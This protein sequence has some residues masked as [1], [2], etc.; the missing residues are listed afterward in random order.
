MSHL[1]LMIVL[2]LWTLLVTDGPLAVAQ[3]QL[4]SGEYFVTQ[5]WSQ[6]KDYR[7]VFYVS[8]PKRRGQQKLPV[9]IFLHGNGGNAK[10]AM[11]GFLA[12]H[13]IM[14]TR[15]VMVF[16]GGYAKSWNIVSERSKAD[17]RGFIEEIVRKLAAFDNVQPDTFTIMGASN[18]AALVNQLAIE[19]RLSNIRNYVSS[20]SPLN[21][22]QHDGQNFKAKGDDNNYQAVVTPMTGKRLMNISGM[23]DKLVPYRGGP[24]KVIPAKGGKLAF[25][26]AEESI[27]RWARQMEYDG[28]KLSAPTTIDGKL[29]IF[30]Y[31]DGDVVHYKVVDE[32]HN[33]TG[34][35]SESILLDFLEQD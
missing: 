32:G 27:F 33:A 15:Y 11:K 17:D 29:E 16:P 24:S 19:C 31:L 26:D 9:F 12:R 35:I 14:A 34:Q 5:S 28:D 25:V 2:A 1:Q 3:E 8:V 21:V 10:G 7:R 20:V 4:T 6:E 30:S 18:G 22:Y 13:R 23:N